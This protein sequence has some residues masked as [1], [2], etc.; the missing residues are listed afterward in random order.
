MRAYEVRVSYGTSGWQ[1]AGVFTQARR[2][3]LQD[4]MPGASNNVQARAVEGSTGYGY[5]SNP[6]RTW[7]CKSCALLI[8]FSTSRRFHFGSRRS[9]F[10]I[11]SV[12][13]RLSIAVRSLKNGFPIFF[14]RDSFAGTFVLRF[15][16]S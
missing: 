15:F 9:S 16:C 4:L 1:T 13:S 11:L 5:W 14:F 2:S 6:F 12:V 10:L 7:R 8:E 3:V